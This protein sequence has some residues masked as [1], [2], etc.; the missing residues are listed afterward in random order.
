MQN[1]LFC[2][3]ETFDLHFSP[4]FSRK[5]HVRS[6]IP[7]IPIS[8]PTWV[9]FRLLSRPRKFAR[10]E[11]EKSVWV[12]RPSVNWFSG[13]EENRY[14]FHVL[15]GQFANAWTWK[16]INR[17]SFSCVSA[18]VFLTWFFFLLVVRS[19]GLPDDLNYIFFFPN[20]FFSPSISWDLLFFVISDD[21]C[22]FVIRPCNCWWTDK[23]CVCVSKVVRKVQQCHGGR[24]WKICSS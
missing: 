24:I 23:I 14:F 19:S 5:H 11:A 21:D 10:K 6:G 17:E 20:F 18:K 22:N 3:W 8:L 7:N 4:S 12:P 1:K 13:T 9:T 2:K 16:N 15:V